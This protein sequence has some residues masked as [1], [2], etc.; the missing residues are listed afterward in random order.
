[1]A[2]MTLRLVETKQVA[3]ATMSFRLELNGQSFPFKPGQYVRFGLSDPPYPDPKGNVRSFSIASAPGDPFLLVAT[4]MTGSA[5]K[6]SLA[7]APIGMPISIGGPA[8]SFILDPDSDAPAAMF[9]GGI[10]ITPFRSMIRHAMENN[11]PRRVTLVYANRCAEQAAFLDE[12]EAWAT[13]NANFRLLA[14]MT[15]PEKSKKGWNGQTGHVDA[16]FIR[17][18]LQENP[19]GGCYVAGPPGFVAGV[20]RALREAGIGDKRVQTEEFT[21]Y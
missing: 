5:F 7:E 21:G 2:K 13:E 12:L 4:R 11:T 17:R 10:G 3:E 9:A 15:Q 19:S 8:G 6:K 14:T 16:G 20:T 18:H 1:M